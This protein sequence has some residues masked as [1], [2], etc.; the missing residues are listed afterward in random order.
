MKFSF[1]RMDYAINPFQ[2]L[3]LCVDDDNYDDS[4]RNSLT[5]N[6]YKLLNIDPSIQAEALFRKYFY[7]AGYHKFLW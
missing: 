6:I 3:Y 2:Y 4:D 5:S 7:E 1:K